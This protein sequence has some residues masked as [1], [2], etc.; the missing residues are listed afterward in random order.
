[1]NTTAA[2]INRCGREQQRFAY[3]LNPRAARRGG[4][5]LEL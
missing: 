4:A 2:P 3:F 5:R 1:M